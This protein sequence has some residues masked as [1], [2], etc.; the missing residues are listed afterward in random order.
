M[1]Y[2]AWD[3]KQRLDEEGYTPQNVGEL[4]Y[5]MTKIVLSGEDQTRRLEV[6]AEIY[7]SEQGPMRFAV[8]AEVLGAF[9][10]TELEYYRRMDASEFFNARVHPLQQARANFYR[11]HVAPYENRKI[12]ENGDVFS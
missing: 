4:T 9:T 10:A 5:V 8:F 12:A 2:I 3:A 11:I 1:P 6:A 7:A